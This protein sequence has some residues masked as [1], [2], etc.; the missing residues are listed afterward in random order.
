MLAAAAVLGREFEFEVL[1]RMS[2]LG[3]DA[4][5]SA[6]E[7]G[8]SARMVVESQGRG[9]PRYAFTHALVRQTLVEELSLPRRQRLHLRAAQAI[10]GVHQRNLEPYLSALA[11]H[12]RIAGAAAD[13][14]KT[15]D[16]SVRAGT[17]AYEVFAYEEAAKHWRA[18]LELMDEQGGGD[19][20]LRARVLWL[21]GDELVSG[22]PK[23]IEYLE[24]A[25]LLYEEQGD[26]EGSADVHTRLGDYL[27]EGDF[28]AVD[29]WRAMDHFKRA[30]AQLV[31]QPESQRYALFY[32]SIAVAC[33]WTKWI[34]D[35]LAAAKRAMEVG[36]HLNDDSLRAAGEAMTSYFLVASGSVTEALRLADQ[37]RQRADPINETWVGRRVAK[38]G[39]DNYLQLWDPREAQDWCT[40]ELAKPRTSQSEAIR[41]VLLIE[42]LT[43]AFIEMGELAKARTCLAEANAEKTPAWLLFFE[44]EWE[45]ADKML[46]EWSELSEHKRTWNRWE[47]LWIA[48]ALARLHGPAGKSTRAL[49]FLKKALDFSVKNGDIIHELVARFTLATIAAD[50]G[51]SSDALSHLQRCRQIVSAGENWRG[52]AGGVERAEAVFAAA[53]GEHPLAEAQFEKA[54]ATF[55]HYGLPWEEADTLQYWGRALL[56]AGAR[57]RAIE[58]F[59]AAIEVYHS[60]GVGTRFI[61]CVVADKMRTQGSTATLPGVQ[62]QLT[63]PGQAVGVAT[64]RRVSTIM[65]LDIVDS[66][67]HAARV[68]DSQWNRVLEQYFAVVRKELKTFRGREVDTSGDGFFA[69]F[70]GPGQAIRCACAIRAALLEI[71]LQIRVGIHTGEC[72]FSGDKV[73]GIAVHIGARVIR[74]AEP[75]EVMVSATVRDLV[76]GAGLEFSDRGVHELRG[77]PGEWRL[78]VVS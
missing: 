14:E 42:V 12:Y 61:E 59:D 40:R 48:G 68:G 75:G 23:A 6:V 63:E 29:M 71:G 53:H 56:A 76:A 39:S 43:T 44:G 10:E 58:R 31:A 13:T 37:A 2:E 24:A 50:E 49:R 15:I 51:E 19:R 1:S 54:I 3:E 66:T 21:L 35:G 70:D 11:N 36:E 17:A 25:A 32:L 73:S 67:E 77:I 16:Y 45:R 74:K 4:I 65:F 55:R 5:L 64:E 7:E 27:S 46:T 57:A 72:E 52:L 8:L 9:G 69:L 38:V 78:F 41:R 47:D 30:E 62:A 60:R 18:A 28:G 33:A 34:G 22:G 20:A 26:N